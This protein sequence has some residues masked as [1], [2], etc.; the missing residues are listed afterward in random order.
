MGPQSEA[1]N[2]LHSMKHRMPGETF[3]DVCN[4]VAQAL[5]DSGDHYH[6]FRDILIKQ[7]F[8][9]GGRIPTGIGTSKQ[10]TPYNCFV[11]GTINDSFTS[12]E[13]SIMQRAHQA[14]STMRMGGGIGYDFSRLRPRGELIAAL[15]SQASGPVSFMRIYNEV[16]LVTASS[17]HR[18]GA[19]MGILRVDHPDIE[20]FI[21]AKHN[22]D[23][24]TGFN[25]SIAVTD[26]FMRCVEAGD[27]FPLRWA[28]KVYRTVDARGLWEMIMRSTWDWAEPG[29][30]FIDRVNAMNNLYYCEEI[31]ATNPC[32]EQPLPPFGA[33]LLGSFNLVKYLVPV[34]RP[35]VVGEP[36][37]WFDYASLRND[38]PHVVRAMDN[39]VDRAIYPLEEQA[40]EARHKRRMGLG[41][42]GLANAGEALGFPYGSSDFLIFTEEVLETIRDE[43]YLAS[44]RLAAEK[45]PFPKFQKDA[46]LEG[47]FVENLRADVRDAIGRFG[48]RNSHLIS[49]APTATISFCADNVSS[50]LEPVYSHYVDRPVYMPHGLET[51]KNVPDY[52]VA[53][54]GVYGKTAEEVSAE[55]HIAVLTTAQ[56]FVDSGISKT[57]NVPADMPWGQFKELYFQAWR[58]G[59]KSCSTFNIGGKRFGLLK[60][61]EPQEPAEC[62]S[63]AC[64]I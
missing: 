20:E 50:G 9:P 48:I 25:L 40:Q 21:L 3:R 62:A 52:G 12:G 47:R 57:C 24:L 46:Y 5:A 19:Q 1:A 18:R 31:E 44:A 38:I 33:C 51:F 7:R 28:G 43:A 8:M 56:R 61:S 22:N 29:V 42:T 60:E 30:I 6:L 14:A 4:R 34:D 32:G 63:G 10:V 41:V 17:G 45:G 2:A 58:G 37:F 54:L 64:A 13:G 36:C 23:Q 55:E 15:Q 26:E 16:G 27:Q 35:M 59:A 49:I 53:Y 11:S 39:V